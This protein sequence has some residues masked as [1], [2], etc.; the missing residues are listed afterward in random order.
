M[1]WLPTYPT[2][3]CP[4]S[5]AAP[6][7]PA[8]Q[9]CSP[10]RA[11]RRSPS[12]ALAASA[13]LAWRSKPPASP[14]CPSPAPASS[15]CPSPPRPPPTSWP[16]PLPAGSSGPRAAKTPRCSSST[17]LAPR[18]CLLVLDGFD[19]ALPGA[20]L[21]SQILERAPASSC[22]PPPARAWACPVSRSSSSAACLCLPQPPPPPLI[23]APN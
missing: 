5:A 18:Q 13:K 14:T 6:S 22:S 2:T 4:S 16:P 11:C 20:A 12:P 1:P 21:L 23:L 10:P 9:T 7:L 15:S 8:W 17:W 19:Q 3:G